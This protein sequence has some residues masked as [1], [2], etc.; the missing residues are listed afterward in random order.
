MGLLNIA[1]LGTLY[2]G[3]AGIVHG[4]L[5]STEFGRNLSPIA[6]EVL[7]YAPFSI[8]GI[9]SAV[10][11]AKD[12]FWCYNSASPITTSAFAATAEGIGYCIGKIGGY[13][14][15]KFLE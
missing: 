13:G 3:L 9:S 8:A 5:D 7:T 12:D 2:S 14:I 10:Y 6:H 1:V 15:Q 4:A 11:I